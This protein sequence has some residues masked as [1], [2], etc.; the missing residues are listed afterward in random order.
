MT[1]KSV[2]QTRCSLLASADLGRRRFGCRGALDQTRHRIG[3]LGAL[4]LP[5]VD[6]IEREAQCLFVFSRDRIVEAD[7]LDESAIAPITR[8]GDDDI[9]KRPLLGAAA[10]QSDDDHASCLIY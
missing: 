6:T 3:E 7:A 8:V 9:E 2:A 1:T 4:A 10:S 5:V